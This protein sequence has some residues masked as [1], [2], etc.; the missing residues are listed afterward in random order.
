M[1]LE[2]SLTEV[3]DLNFTTVEVSITDTSIILGYNRAHGDG[4]DIVFKLV[5]Y[6]APTDM[7]PGQPI[8]LAP[9]PDG[10]PRAAA[11]RSVAD[12]PIRN[13]AAIKTGELTFQAP[14]ELDKPNS[15]DFRVTLGEGGDAGKGR[16]AF[17]NFKVLRVVPGS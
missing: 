11:T 8:N 12:D 6:T 3:L 14:L 17:G 9:A 13:L 4:R 16:T 7:T 10:T 1:S 5:A 15:G 2:G